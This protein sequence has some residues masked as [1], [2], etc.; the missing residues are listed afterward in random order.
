LSLHTELGILFDPS[1]IKRSKEL[2]PS[3]VDALKVEK[4]AGALL[5]L[6]GHPVEQMAL[7]NKMHPDTSA[8]LCRWLDDPVF[9]AVV[10][11]ISRQ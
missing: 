2:E 11:G 3:E 6:K 9:W 4:A 5:R 8:A 7:V 10:G 1:T